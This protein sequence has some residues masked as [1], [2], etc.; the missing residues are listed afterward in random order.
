MSMRRQ[1][2]AL[3]WLGSVAASATAT[4][5][6]PVCDDSKNNAEDKQCMAAE[7]EKAHEKLADYLAVAKERIATQK[8]QGVDLDTAQAD[9][10]RYRTAHCRDVYQYWIEG[11][12]RHRAGA[13]CVLELTQTRTRD[14]W[15][16][17]LTFADSTPPLRPEP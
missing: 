11:T 4:A 1:L 17:Y 15:S 6:K 5:A 10:L 12:H 9:W 13:Q 2:V 7:V 3:V 16:A 8:I 14:I